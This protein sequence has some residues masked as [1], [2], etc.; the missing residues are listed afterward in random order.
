[1]G[2][3]FSGGELCK[4]VEVVGRLIQVWNDLGNL[5]N[6]TAVRT[7]NGLSGPVVLDPNLSLAVRASELDH[8]NAPNKTLFLRRTT[9]A[10][11]NGYG[12]LTSARLVAILNAQIIQALGVLLK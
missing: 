11:R 1:L 9:Y 4:H 10:V 6:F 2:L 3:G 5:A 8:K 12:L 7:L